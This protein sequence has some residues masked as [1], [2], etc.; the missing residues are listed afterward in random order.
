MNTRLLKT[1]KNIAKFRKP[2]LPFSTAIL[3]ASLCVSSVQ[4]ADLI[5]TGG[6]GAWNAAANWTPAQ[7]PGPSDNAFITNSGTY[8]VT[9]PAGSTATVG[10]LTVGGASGAQTLSIDRA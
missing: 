7:V 3:T 5:W 6:T 9:V 4:A 8:I 10:G 2:F 1:A